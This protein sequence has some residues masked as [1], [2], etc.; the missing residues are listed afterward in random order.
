MSK[1][2]SI[3]AREGLEKSESA[4]KQALDL[5]PD[6]PAAHKAYAQL[7]VD[8]GRAG[9]AMT[10]L[11][12][13]ARELADPEVFAG[14]VSPLRYCGLLE[15]SVCAHARARALE[16]KVRTSV[17]HTWFL[18][19]DYKRLAAVKLEE[20]PYI[21]AL[22]LMELGRKEQPLPGLRMLEE[23]LKTR[24]RD[25]VIAART[26]LEDDTKASVA[27]IGRVIASDFGDPEGLF[28]LARNLSR[29]Q[30]T[31]AALELLERVIGGGYS[32]YPAFATDP[33]LEPLRETP[34]FA[35]LLSQAEKEHRAAQ[36]DFT[37]LGGD[38]IF[39][40]NAGQQP[41]A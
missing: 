32:C 30:Q 3:G 4:F 6:L 17:P 40:I 14:L 31:E 21:V 24:I 12:E 15:A 11:L 22:A 36:S 5:N 19:R 7:E 23:K 28:Y 27:A 16:P 10:R 8:L 33:W 1:Y 20:F 26:L 34:R 25:F 41:L 39:G 29:L 2:L 18:Q 9:D 37:R 13:Q 38:R 35:K